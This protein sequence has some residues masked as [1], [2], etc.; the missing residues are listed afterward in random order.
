MVSAGKDHKVLYFPLAESQGITGDK[1]SG[2]DWRKRIMT[3]SI[4]YSKVCSTYQAECFKFFYED[5]CW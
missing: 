3:F 5:C 2:K 4:F 1:Q